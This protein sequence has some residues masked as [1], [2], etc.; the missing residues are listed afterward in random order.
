MAVESGADGIIVSNYRGRQLDHASATLDVLTEIVAA[1]DGRILVHFDGR[2]RRGSDIFKAIALGANFV[3]IGR[4]ALW[5]LAV[6]G[7]QGVVRVLEILENE[8]KDCMTLAG[9]TDIQQLGLGGRNWL[10]RISSADE[11][12]LSRGSK[13]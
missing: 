1:V 13:L 8:F 7:Q 4:P 10:K 6:A 3:W 9:C 5:G 2:V 12:S 11:D